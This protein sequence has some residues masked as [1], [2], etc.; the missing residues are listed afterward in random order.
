MKS[1]LFMGAIL[2]AQLSF[3]QQ[4]TDSLIVP[5]AKTEAELKAEK[6]TLKAEKQQLKAEKKAQKAKEKAQK[7]A[8]RAEKK[9]KSLST[10]RKTKKRVR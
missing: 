9:D 5:M 8:E 4:V 6:E 3:A 7:E 2:L 10:S 1:Y